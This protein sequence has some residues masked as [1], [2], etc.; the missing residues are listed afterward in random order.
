MM[1]LGDV[2]GSVVPKPVLVTDGDDAM[3]VTSRYFTPRRAHISHAVTGA[4]GVATAFALPGTVAHRGEVPTGTHDIAILHPQGRIEVGVEVVAEQGEITVRRA[5]LF[6]TARKILEG[7]LHLPGYVFSRPRTEQP[8]G[9]TSAAARSGGPITLIVPTPAGGAND[10]IARAI[11]HRLGPIIGRSVVVDNR[12]G[13]HGSIASEYVARAVPDGHTLLL[14]YVATHGMNPALQRLGYDPVADFEPV[15]LI[16]YSPTVLVSS[17]SMPART[18]EELV[19]RLKAEPGVHSYASAGDGT[20]PHFA[21]ELFKLAADVDITG[22]T[23]RGSSDALGDTVAGRTQLMFPSLSTAHPWIRTGRLHALAIAAPSRAASLPDVPTLHE[24]GVTGVEVT[25]WYGLFAPAGTP[26]R[27]VEDINTALNEVLNQVLTQTDSAA[28]VST[29]GIDIVA[30][31]PGELSKLVEQE[32][33][34]WKEVVGRTG[35][36]RNR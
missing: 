6:R 35:L 26:G 36:S 31:P 25:Q 19:A 10:T 29:Q 27:V 18:V 15:G 21:A 30:G 8:V 14:G 5:G 28:Q 16:G 34:R 9:D 22:V 12:A 2:S 20:A 32:V 33:A 23:H 3:S 13:A 24:A 11:A 17:P 4:I 7:E 1:G